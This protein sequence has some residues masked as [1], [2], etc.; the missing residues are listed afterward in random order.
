MHEETVSPELDLTLVIGHTF[1]AARYE[2][3]RIAHLRP[4]DVEKITQDCLIM[5]NGAEFRAISGEFSEDVEMM[6]G[7]SAKVVFVGDLGKIDPRVYEMARHI[8]RRSLGEFVSRLHN[9]TG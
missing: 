6:R 7:Y 5:K 8:E 9:Q 4:D 2:L 1:R 3:R